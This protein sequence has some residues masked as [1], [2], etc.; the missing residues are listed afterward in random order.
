MGVR[1]RLTSGHREDR[2]APRTNPHSRLPPYQSRRQQRLRHRAGFTVGPDADSQRLFRPADG[3]GM[4]TTV[5]DALEYL[6]AGWSVIPIRYGAKVSAVQ[7]WEPWQSAR[8]DAAKIQKWFRESGRHNIAVILGPVSG[9]LICRD[10]DRLESYEAWAAEHRELA[11]SLPTVETSK[12]RHLYCRADFGTIA[13]DEDIQRRKFV[14][15]GDGELRL[16]GCYCLLPPSI[17]PDRT[18]YHWAKPIRL[19]LPVLDVRQAG[20]LPVTRNRDN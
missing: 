20:F 17:H 16:Q 13:S 18:L 15:L 10:F 5:A 2:S 1:H 14:T 12:G 7:S 6:E 19:D 8:P 9:D 3:S 11:K 4:M